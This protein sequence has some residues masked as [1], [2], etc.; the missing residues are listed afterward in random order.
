MMIA[1]AAIARV[2]SGNIIDRLQNQLDGPDRRRNRKD[3]FNRRSDE[4]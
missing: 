3:A 1:L 4:P 2:Y